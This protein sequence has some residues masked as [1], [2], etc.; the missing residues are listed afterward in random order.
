MRFTI[1]YWIEC[2]NEQEMNSTERASFM[3]KLREVGMSLADYIQALRLPPPEAS[4][5]SNDQTVRQY[6]KFRWPGPCCIPNHP[7]LHGAAE[8]NCASVH[9]PQPGVISVAQDSTRW[10]GGPTVLQS[11]SSDSV[12]AP[13]GFFSAKISSA[14]DEPAFDK[15]FEKPLTWAMF[16]SIFFQSIFRYYMGILIFLYWAHSIQLTIFKN[17]NIEIKS[18]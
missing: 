5:G 7:V 13:T 15:A 11:M 3:K 6:Q 9:C 16:V 10:K 17:K 2:F 4:R 14:P 8:W 18:M 12:F 1:R